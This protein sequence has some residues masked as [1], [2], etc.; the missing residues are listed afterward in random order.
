MKEETYKQYE[1]FVSQI[2]KVVYQDE[3]LDFR[4]HAFKFVLSDSLQE[5]QKIALREQIIKQA[6]TLKDEYSRISMQNAISQICHF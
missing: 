5:T 1:E 2:K 3:W 6:N 4:N